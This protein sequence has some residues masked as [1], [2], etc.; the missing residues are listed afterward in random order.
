MSIDDPETFWGLAVF[1]L[2]NLGVFIYALH[3]DFKDRHQEPHG[4]APRR[5][6]VPF[7]APTPPDPPSTAGNTPR[8]RPAIAVTIIQPKENAMPLSKGTSKKAIAKNIKTEVA[9]GKPKAQAVAIALNTQ[10]QAQ[11][12]ARPKRSK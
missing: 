12:E 11:S 3:R 2:A 1:C 5:P 9:A 10:R 8:S 4:N 7:G 6:T